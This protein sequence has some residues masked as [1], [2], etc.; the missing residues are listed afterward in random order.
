MNEY[1]ENMSEYAEESRQVEYAENKADKIWR[2]KMK[3]VNM[4]EYAEQNPEKI[5]MGAYAEKICK[6]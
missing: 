1:E 2:T 5:N 6:T 4:G 3:V